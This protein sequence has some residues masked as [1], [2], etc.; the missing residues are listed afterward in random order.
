ASQGSIGIIT[1]DTP[2]ACSPPCD[3]CGIEPLPKRVPPTPA[4]RRGRRCAT[5]FPPP[6]LPPQHYYPL[7]DLFAHPPLLR[8]ERESGLPPQESLPT[9]PAMQRIPTPQRG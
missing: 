4:S 3:P 6:L 7:R 5:G 8:R 9:S 2:P 1:I